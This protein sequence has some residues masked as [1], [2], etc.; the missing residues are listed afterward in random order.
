VSRKELAK[1][2]LRRLKAEYGLPSFAREG[3]RSLVDHLVQTVL[4]QKTASE[5]CSQAFDRLTE[6]RDWEDIAAMTSRQ[7]ASKIERAG[8]ADQKAPRILQTL[9]QIKEEQG[10]I[11]LEYL[12]DRPTADIRCTLCQFPGVGPKTA[13][14]V[15]M[16]GMGRKVLPVDTH[17]FRVTR[18][19][20][21]LGEEIPLARASDELEEVVKPADRYAMH[22]NLFR[23]GRAVCRSARPRCSACC[24][25]NLCPYPE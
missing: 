11:S 2:V 6:G 12:R 24:L 10:Q 8:L 19:L 22:V 5:A 14:C 23:H 20:G 1:K 15:L 3:G 7:I 13:D 21:L 9:H 25:R 16:F 17:V 4:S 18:R